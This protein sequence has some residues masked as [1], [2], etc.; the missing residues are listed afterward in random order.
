MKEGKELDLHRSG[1]S[2][3]QISQGWGGVEA[4][5]GNG[6][7]KCTEMVKPT[8]CW[9]TEGPLESDHVVWSKDARSLGR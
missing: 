8:A 3:L 9:E 2:T 6:M 1:R 4:G 7:S 5:G